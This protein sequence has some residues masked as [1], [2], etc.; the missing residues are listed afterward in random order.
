MSILSAGELEQL[1]A[2]AL[3][4]LP[5]A[6][7]LVQITETSDG[8][9]GWADT[10]SGTILTQCQL[11]PESEEGYESTLAGRERDQMPIIATFPGTVI[12]DAG[13]KLRQGGR[14]FQI[15]TIKAYRADA[16]VIEA[17]CFEVD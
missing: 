7:T 4:V 15:D 17:F 16:F 9:G 11:L 2:D 12:V 13:Y 5:L 1:R 10:E 14:S 8:R 3:T 6:G